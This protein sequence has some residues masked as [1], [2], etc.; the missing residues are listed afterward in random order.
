MSLWNKFSNLNTINKICIFIIIFIILVT[1]IFLEFIKTRNTSQQ[2]ASILTN[3]DL[4]NTEV[5]TE[6]IIIENKEENVQEEV[7][8][9]IIEN[10]IIT[11]KE[12]NTEV[13]KQADNNKTEKVE[14]QVTT[15]KKEDTNT[16]KKEVTENVQKQDKVDNNKTDNNQKENSQVNNSETN[17]EQNKNEQQNV[18]TNKEQDNTNSSL[19]NTHFTKYNAEKTAHAVAYINNKIKKMDNYEELGGEAIAVT[20][21]PCKNWFSYSYDEKLNSLCIT[22]CTMKVYVEDEYRYDSR[23]IN[24]YLYDTKAYIYQY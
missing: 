24:Y 20:Q 5:A 10:E 19:A 13:V 2:Q 12:D 8:Q 15:S 21:K 4:Q 6:N 16:N 17:N 7:N 22:G 1:A 23:G 18:E 9:E 11:T 3:E 14:S